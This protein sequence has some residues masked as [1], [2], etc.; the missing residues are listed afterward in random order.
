MDALSAQLLTASQIGEWSSALLGG[1]RSLLFAVIVFVAGLVLAEV[2][3]VLGVALLRLLRWDGLC[4]RVGLTAQLH[5]H[6]RDLTPSTLVGELLFWFIL[7]SGA[8]QALQQ[9]EIGWLA[10]LGRA[11]FAILPLAAQAAVTLLVVW[12]LALALGRLILAVVDHPAAVL[13]AGLVQA[14]TLSLGLFSALETL[15]VERTLS[16]PMTLVL[17][18]AATL[19]IALGWAFHRTTLFRTT[20]RVPDETEGGR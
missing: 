10:A 14:L 6:R 8:M 20:I 9:L 2:T 18:A 17:L 13:G 19:A 5:R 16:L 15:G 4:D 3:K 11:Y 7:L 1:V 12:W